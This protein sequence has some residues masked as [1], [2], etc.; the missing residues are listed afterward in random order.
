M[1][2]T[3]SAI[4]ASKKRTQLQQQ[5]ATISPTDQTGQRFE[6]PATMGTVNE[7]SPTPGQTPMTSGPTN[8]GV[9][10]ASKPTSAPMNKISNGS[11]LKNADINYS[12]YGDDSSAKNQGQA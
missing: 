9:V 3:S 4:E 7:I 11:G 5:N 12:Q 6:Q 1:A 8:P 2:V 10:T